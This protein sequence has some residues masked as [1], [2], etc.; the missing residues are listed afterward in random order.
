LAV[1]ERLGSFKERPLKKEVVFA[2]A[3]YAVG[4]RLGYMYTSG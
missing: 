1:C 4:E 2:G 3:V